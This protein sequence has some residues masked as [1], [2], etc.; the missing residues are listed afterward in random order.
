MA[1]K[2]ARKAAARNRP[3]VRK[4]AS[5]DSEASD[6]PSDDEREELDEVF[7][8][9]AVRAKRASI[10]T[11]REEQMVDEDGFSAAEMSA[12]IAASTAAPTSAAERAGKLGDDVLS[13]L[14]DLMRSDQ[15]DNSEVLNRLH[16]VGASL[17]R[18]KRALE[19]S[20]QQQ[21]DGAGIGA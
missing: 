15:V 3:A 7:E 8:R 20:E 14:G 1:R 6:H 16:N 17:F 13:L 21:D 10:E 18:V 12:A 19:A 11:H 4:S 9:R 5:A 2:P